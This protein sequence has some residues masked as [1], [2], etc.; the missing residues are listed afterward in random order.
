MNLEKTLKYTRLVLATIFMAAAIVLPQ[1][2]D[3]HPYMIP[4]YYGLMLWSLGVVT[5]L[6]EEIVSQAV[7]NESNTCNRASKAKFKKSLRVKGSKK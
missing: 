1:A 7:K 6:R 4:F 3:A 5:V 2:L